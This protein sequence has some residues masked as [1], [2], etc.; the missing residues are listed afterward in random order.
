MATR[1]SSNLHNS[2]LSDLSVSTASHLVIFIDIL[3]DGYPQSSEDSPRP[4]WESH[5]VI[6]VS[7]YPRRLDCIDPTVAFA[8]HLPILATSRFTV[9]SDDTAHIETSPL[10][11]I[12]AP[13]PDPAFLYRTALVPASWRTILESPGVFSLFSGNAVS[14]N[15]SV[16]DPTRYT[17][18]HQVVNIDGAVVYSATY[19]FRYT[20]RFKSPVSSAS[21]GTFAEFP[22]QHPQSVGVAATAKH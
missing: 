12:D 17:I 9:C 3:P 20:T 14:F 15:A 6:H 11:L 21:H 22:S 18:F 10:T 7:S 4:W 2:P 16:P 5:N 19:C 1:T 8:A 13:L